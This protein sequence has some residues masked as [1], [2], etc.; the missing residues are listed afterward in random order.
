MTLLWY[1]KRRFGLN[2]Q[3]S[4][5]HTQQQ[6]RLKRLPLCSHPAISDLEPGGSSKMVIHTYNLYSYGWLMASSLS[7]SELSKR[8][9]LLPSKTRW[10]L[11]RVGGTICQTWIQPSALPTAQCRPSGLYTFRIFPM[12]RLV[13]LRRSDYKKVIHKNYSQKRDKKI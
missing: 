11:I 6:R 4:R 5:D 10:S 8:P 13:T 1:S 9:T 7:N 3:Q 12:P 2:S